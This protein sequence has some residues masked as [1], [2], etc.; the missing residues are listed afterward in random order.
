MEIKPQFEVGR[1]KVGKGGVVRDPALHQGVVERISGWIDA[2]GWT[3][4]GTEPSPILGPQGN[5][6]FLLA[7]ARDERPDC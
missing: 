4:L 2:Q 3:V 5:R 7:A 6:E 1:G